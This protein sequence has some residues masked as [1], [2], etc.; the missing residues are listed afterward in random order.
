MWDDDDDGPP[1]GK[2]DLLPWSHEHASSASSP[3]VDMGETSQIKRRRNNKSVSELMSM[4]PAQPDRAT[5]HFVAWLST[6]GSDRI[7]WDEDTFQLIIDGVR[8]NNSSLVDILTFLEDEEPIGDKM[9]V[10]SHTTGDFHGI[11][12]GTTHFINIVDQELYSDSFIE[13]TPFEEDMY[14][15]HMREL[16]CFL[17]KNYGMNPD[18]I[19]QVMDVSLEAKKKM[20][21]HTIV[22]TAEAKQKKERKRDKTERDKV[23]INEVM[24][25]VREEEEKKMREEVGKKICEGQSMQLEEIYANMPRDLAMA[26]F[27]MSKKPSITKRGEMERKVHKKMEKKGKPKWVVGMLL[28]QM[29]EKKG[30]NEPGNPIARLGTAI[31]KEAYKVAQR[32]DLTKGE[33]M[34]EIKKIIDQI[35]EKHEVLESHHQAT[36]GKKKESTA[37]DDEDYELESDDDDDDD[38]D[39]D[40][41]GG[42]DMTELMDVGLAYLQDEEKRKKETEAKKLDIATGGDEEVTEGDYE[43]R[44]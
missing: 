11:L 22:K 3:L 44:D 35:K 18:K 28:E 2:V 40:G 16:S 19:K 24:R 33:K 32:K 13:E 42:N 10:T 4:L 38:D 37:G 26:K 29:L 31:Q 25:K 12:M 34:E 9:F 5:C 30:W 17:E 14:K 36:K 7:D 21:Y 23:V 1:K 20:R 27:R 15:H 43:E 39:D 8:K 6:M 41:G